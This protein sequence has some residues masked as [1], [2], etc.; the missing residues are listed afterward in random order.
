M[1][2]NY[3][4]PYHFLD[5]TKENSNYIK[6]E[7]EEMEVKISIDLGE[8]NLNSDVDIL[9]EVECTNTFYRKS[10]VLKE[11]KS[12]FRI[13]NDQLGS[14]ANYG[15]YLIAKKEGEIVINDQSDYYEYGDC[16]G[17]L[18]KNTI[19][20]EE[21]EGFSGLI[22]ISPTNKD[23]ISY[24]L[25]SDWIT[26]ELPKNTYEKFYPWQKDNS[27]IPFALASLGASCVQFAILQAFRQD[28]FKE[29]RWWETISK[30]LEDAGYDIEE[31]DHDAIPGATNQILGNCF[32]DMA[33]AALPEV[34]D[35]DTSILA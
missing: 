1:K 29:Y 8:Y 6:S 32:Q 15:L 4:F 5:L 18:E 19:I 34:D 2:T 7:I 21:E 11:N 3:N 20:L 17:I 23:V 24:D 13:R 33:N 10:F 30:L 25:T 14:N 35:G 26:I 28:Q 16:I 22:K 27:T 31:L 9:L 12:T